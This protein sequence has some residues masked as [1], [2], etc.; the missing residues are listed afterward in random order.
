[1]TLV[2]KENLNGDGT[3]NFRKLI[4]KIIEKSNSKEWST[5]T[6]E[7]DEFGRGYADGGYNC[8][9]GHFIKELCYIRNKYTHAECIVGNCCIKNFMKTD[10]TTFF[11]GLAKIRN[12]KLESVNVAV[13]RYAYKDGILGEWDASWY[14]SNLRAKHLSDLEMRLKY[15]L[16]KKILAAYNKDN[17]GKTQ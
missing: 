12:D 15:R 6:L 4:T 16:N 8:L 17:G 5:A 1:M 10:G 11:R 3:V 7:W 14:I 13:I 9:C 2:T